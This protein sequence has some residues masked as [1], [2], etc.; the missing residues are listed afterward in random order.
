MYVASN[1]TTEATKLEDKNST[2][3]QESHQAQEQLQISPTT[4][5]THD[6]NNLA[7]NVIFYDA[8]WERRT[9]SELGHAGLRVIITM[10]DNLHLQQLHVSALSPPVSSALQAETYGLLLA[11]K[12]ADLLQVQNPHFYT[13]CSVLASATRSSTVFAA[14]GCWENIPLLAEIPAS[15]SFNCN[16]ITHISG[17]KNVKVDHQA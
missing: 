5:H 4:I 7:G 2:Q 6:S 3:Q 16:K 10:Q 14:P 17:S 11:T 13:D 9:D 15:C 12:L 8:A 1:V